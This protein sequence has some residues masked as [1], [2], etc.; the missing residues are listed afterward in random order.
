MS[1][2]AVIRYLLANAATLTSDVAATKIRAGVL[3]I[4]TLPPAI[5]VTQ[6]NS[7]PR[8]TVDMV[9]TGRMHTD[10]VR[11][12]VLVADENGRGYPSLRS[13][14]A[15]VLAACPHTRGTVSGIK[16]DSILPG[17]EG[18]DIPSDQPSQLSCTRDFIVRWTT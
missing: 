15:K 11:V 8:L 7:D 2:V 13:I 10:I 12:T 9:T 14:L 16:V 6:I 5:S 1:G 17:P 3:P 18:P 4:G